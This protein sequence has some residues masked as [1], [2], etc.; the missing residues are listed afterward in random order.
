MLNLFSSNILLKDSDPYV[1]PKSFHKELLFYLTPYQ[2]KVADNL[3]TLFV[4]CKK[5]QNKINA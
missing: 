2:T 4:Y 3:S 5:L 1:F